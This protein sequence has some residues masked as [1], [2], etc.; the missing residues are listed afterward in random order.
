MMRVVSVCGFKKGAATTLEMIYLQNE[1]LKRKE[2]FKLLIFDDL[3]EE[4]IKGVGT[5]KFKAMFKLFVELLKADFDVVQ[6][7]KGSPYV[8]FPALLAAKL[9]RKRAVVLLDDYE[10]GITTKRHGKVA[11]AFMGLSEDM[12]IRFS[13]WVVCASEFLFKKA[14]KLNKNSSFTPFGIPERRFNRAKDI[15]K[16]LGLKKN[17]KV[18]IYVGSLTKDADADIAI[19]AMR[20]VDGK[21]LIVGGGEAEPELKDMAN[22]YGVE[23]QVIFC[24]W[25]EFERVPDFIY[26]SDVC[27][28]PMREIDID[29]AR[30]PMKLLEYIAAEKPIVGGN[31]GMVSFFLEQ[32]V[33]LL[34]KPD[35]PMDMGKKVME[36][37]SKKDNKKMI[38]DIRKVKKKYSWKNV[39]GEFLKVYKRVLR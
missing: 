17:D 39:A 15:R 2:E 27:V 18:L 31:V 7:V 26:S 19:T 22:E 9:R 25:Q 3:E 28:I 13:D 37:I 30:C 20:E 32:G 24:G 21:L 35:D 12:I 11:G 34:C 5:D 4:N 1:L 14:K 23:D 10:R 16:E 38:A 29:R 8:G 6:I 36:I 33:G